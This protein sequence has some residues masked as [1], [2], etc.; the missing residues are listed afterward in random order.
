MGRLKAHLQSKLLAGGLAAIPVGVT[1]FIFWYVDSTFRRIF[2]EIHYPFLGIPIALVAIYLL[3]VFGTSL[4]GRWL[5]SVLD[6]V[7]A[8]L[9]GLRDTC[10]TWKLVVVDSD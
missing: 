7:L 9:P 2:P 8:R 6:R 3:G 4:I 1:L 5:L 10:C